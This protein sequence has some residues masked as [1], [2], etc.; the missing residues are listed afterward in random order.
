M[1]T[2]MGIMDKL[3]HELVDII[4]WVDD[5]RHTLVWRFP[6]YQN[7][8][9]N[10]AQLIVRPGQ[11]AI[12]VH[13]GE[14][15]DAF[16]P[17]QHRLTTRNLP[18]LSTLAGWKYGFDSPFKAEV[19]FVSTRQITDMKWGTPNPVIVRDADFGA[20]RLRAFGTYTLKATDAKT[21][22]KELVGADSH[23][24][25]EELTELLRA[26]VSSTFAD[27][28]AS[29]EIPLMDLATNYSTLSEQL[30]QMVI[31]RVDDEYGLDIPQMYIVNIS[32]PAEVEKALD[33]RSSMDIVGDMGRFQAF[34]LGNAM[35]ALAANPGAGGMAGAGMGVGLGMAVAS[36]VPSMVGRGQGPMSP[37]QAPMP[38]QAPPPPSWHIAENGAQVGPFSA[39]Q[40]VELVSAG[41]VRPETLVWVAGMA[42]WMPA[43]QLPQLAGLFGPVPP[44][45][46]GR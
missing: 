41:R 28:V 21:L 43:S 39:P 31:E 22:L 8:I 35:P 46:P 4:E 17:G 38:P 6:R 7:Q 20:V 15:A 27:L 18:V 34:Q 11:Q 32:L 14:I 25:S 1:E 19:Y 45:V 24:E 42:D 23:F 10:G 3:R 9:K 37:A 5:S 16:D 44:P 2:P 12:F 40:M 30:R 36:G 33:T 26:I 29:A 13:Q